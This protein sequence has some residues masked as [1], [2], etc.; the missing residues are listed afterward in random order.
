[1]STATA[2][3]PSVVA[4]GMAAD[5]PIG[6]GQQVTLCQVD[7]GV[8]TYLLEGNATFANGAAANVLTPILN[9]VWDNGRGGFY[10]G[11]GIADCPA[12]AHV[13]LQARGSYQIV[14]PTTVKWQIYA[15]AAG[16]AIAQDPTVSGFCAWLTATRIA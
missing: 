8:G 12:N 11:S 14:T 2:F 13:L 1:M 15:T 5:T 4:V 3:V 10:V 9:A 6:A 7:L 16:T